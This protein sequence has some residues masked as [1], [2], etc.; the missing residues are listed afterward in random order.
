MAKFT[1]KQNQKSYQKCDFL[2]NQF[3]S[4][5]LRY[6]VY[7]VIDLFSVYSKV[8]HHVLCAVV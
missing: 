4:E 6:S 2:Y 3:L 1:V 5:I 7:K 8:C